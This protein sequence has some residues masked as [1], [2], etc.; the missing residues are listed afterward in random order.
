MRGA[1]G[2][3]R[4]VPPEHE[5]LSSNSPLEP[6]KESIRSSCTV[7]G[8]ACVPLNKGA[9][10]PAVRPGRGGRAGQEGEGDECWGRASSLA[11]PYPS[12]R[13]YRRARARTCARHSCGARS[14]WAAAA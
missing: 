9:R 10:Q 7:T 2:T 4:H 12:P 6:S 5:T 11:P 14:R 8:R 3:T 1:V 13:S